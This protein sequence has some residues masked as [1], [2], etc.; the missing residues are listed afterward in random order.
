[1]SPFSPNSIG[2]L[3]HA[4]A[5]HRRLTHIQRRRTGG[6]ER[7]G[8]LRSTKGRRRRWKATQTRRCCWCVRH[9]DDERMVR[10]VR[11]LMLM[12]GRGE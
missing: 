5:G 12:V 2:E 7:R 3:G 4:G 8:R 6:R 9:V 11:M 10:M 1:M